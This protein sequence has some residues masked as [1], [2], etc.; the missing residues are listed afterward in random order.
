M[1]PETMVSCCVGIL[2]LLLWRLSVVRV[3]CEQQLLRDM[4]KIGGRYG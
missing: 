4:K 2:L 1:C 3:G